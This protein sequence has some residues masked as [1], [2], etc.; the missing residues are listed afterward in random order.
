MT[1]DTPDTPTTTDDPFGHITTD[2]VV[3][4]VAAGNDT[5]AALANILGLHTDSIV[6]GQAVDRAVLSMR[7]RRLH[8]VDGSQR[9]EAAPTATVAPQ[10]LEYLRRQSQRRIVRGVH[11]IV[12]DLDHARRQVEAGHKVH[13][14]VFTNLAGQLAD[15]AADAAV[16]EGIDHATHVVTP[17]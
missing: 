4:A 10:V 12:D 6:F 1:A 17:T 8:N 3:A 7:L 16:I 5:P 13:S 9:F 15:L 11:S 14:T 2:V